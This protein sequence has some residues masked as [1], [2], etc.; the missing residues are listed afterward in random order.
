MI[1]GQLDRHEVVR[2]N[3]LERLGM[4]RST[5]A[6]RCE[7]GGP[8]QRLLPGVVLLRNGTPSHRHRARGALVFSGRRSVLTGRAALRCHGFGNWSGAVHVLV[9]ANR[10]VQSTGFVLVERTTR[11]P[12]PE[13]RGGVECAPLPRALLDAARRSSTV[14]EA[15]ALIAEVVQR[16]GVTVA[17]LV[18]E[19]DAGSPRGASRVRRVLHEVAANVH[20]VAEIQAREVWKKSGLPTM[21]FNRKIADRS[22]NFIAMP[23]GWIDEAAFAWDIDS[24]DW[25]LA[26]KH[27]RLTVERRTRMQNHG[28]IVL[29]TLPSA[30]RDD[31][32]RVISDLRAHYALAVSRPRP[33]VYLMQ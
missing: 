8:W 13:E 30:V 10:R 1:L 33:C 16:G 32:A 20:S 7:R 27:Y 29:P 4:S 17:D 22:G 19:L 9:D 28:I 25:H 24:L 18:R 12:E 11:F 14:D 31:P 23:D 26:P 21:H 3:H 6:R 5:I 2:S 15:R